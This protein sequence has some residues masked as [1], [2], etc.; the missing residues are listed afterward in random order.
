MKPMLYRPAHAGFDNFNCI[1]NFGKL[2][3]N[4]GSKLPLILSHYSQLL[5]FGFDKREYI[6]ISTP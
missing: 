4:I 1:S 6:Y 3:Y 5:S 2:T